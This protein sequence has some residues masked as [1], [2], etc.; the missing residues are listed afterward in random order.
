MNKGG[1]QSSGLLSLIMSR[2]KKG[3]LQIFENRDHVNKLKKYEGIIY[4]YDPIFPENG[5]RYFSAKPI[6]K[7]DKM[8]NVGL[9][10]RYTI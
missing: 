6:P 4:G 10:K 1:K 3:M 5:I 8:M 9:F 2:S 7:Q